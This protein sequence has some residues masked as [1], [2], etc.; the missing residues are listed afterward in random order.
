MLP[1]NSPT[2]AA[3]LPRPETVAGGFSLARARHAVADLFAPQAWIY[4]TDLLMTAGVGNVG[5]WTYIFALRQ[6]SEF[7]PGQATAIRLAAAT[8]AFVV[9]ALAFYRLSMFIHELAHLRSG[10]MT[11]FRV[12]W[13]LLCGIPF[14]M[15]SFVYYTHLDHHRRRHFGTQRDGEYLAFGSDSTWAI[16]GYVA[17]SAVLPVLAVFRFLVLGPVSWFVPPLRRWVL[18]HASSMVIDFRYVRPQ[19][20]REESRVILLQESMCFAFLLGLA[21]VPPVFLG[22][23]PIPFLI[24][25]YTISLFIITLNAIRTLGSHRWTNDKH[26]EMS[27][28]G[29]LADSVNVHRRPL[30]SELWGPIGTRYHA[31]H[32]LFPALPYHNMAQAHRRLIA[33]LPT[34]SIYHQTEQPSLTAA[35]VD[36]WRRSARATKRE[37]ERMVRRRKVA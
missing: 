7:L 31:L 21:I 29:Q 28:L 16:V 30:I 26:D 1:E 3:M 18:A 23:W 8:L 27:F 35:L 5:A 6:W 36:L 10:T 4:W 15:P 33:E 14:L 34:G 25:G 12:A 11:G 32:H 17:L 19:P 20:T 13:N 22:R 2:I 9:C 37:A 24:A